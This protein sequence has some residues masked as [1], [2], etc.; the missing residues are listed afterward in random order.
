MITIDWDYLEAGS[1]LEDDPVTPMGSEITVDYSLQEFLQC[2]TVATGNY[3]TYMIDLHLD[4]MDPVANLHGKHFGHS[5]SSPPKA[6]GFCNTMHFW[7]EI[8]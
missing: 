2:K 6:Q 3:S 4:R 7:Q 5:P 8:L 1:A